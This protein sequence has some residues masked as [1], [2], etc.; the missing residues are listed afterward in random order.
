[1]QNSTRW[2]MTSITIQ[3]GF[4]MKRLQNLRIAPRIVIGSQLQ[5]VKRI[6]RIMLFPKKC[7]PFANSVHVLKSKD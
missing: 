4:P 6:G 5:Q 1:M 2:A 3:H 7:E